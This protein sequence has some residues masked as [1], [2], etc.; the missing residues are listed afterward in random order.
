MTDDSRVQAITAALERELEAHHVEVIDESSRHA[1]HAGAAGGGGHYRLVV[2]SAR[3]VGQS[4]VEA[5]RL[6][7]NALADMMST[8]IHA[9]SM[10]TLTPAQWADRERAT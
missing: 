2:V 7:Y 3:F 10:T 6:V 1:G 8:Q 4:Q 9:L 5:Q